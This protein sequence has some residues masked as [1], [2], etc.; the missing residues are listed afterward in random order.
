MDFY[1]MNDTEY[2][3][4]A[5]EEFNMIAPGWELKW[6]HTEP[7]QGEYTY[8]EADAVMNFAAKHKQMTR[9]H[10]LIWHEEVPEWVNSLDKEALRSAIQ[11][12]IVYV[13]KFIS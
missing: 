12:R 8:Q 1:Y 13:V 11:K 10:T 2:D 5:G 7:R 6:A 3:K 4:M 9:G